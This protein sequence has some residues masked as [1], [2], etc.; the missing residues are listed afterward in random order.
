MGWQMD[1]HLVPF[2]TLNS[3]IL[4]NK[5][6]MENWNGRFAIGFSP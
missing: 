2:S 1:H 6:E 4:K 5:N 3:R